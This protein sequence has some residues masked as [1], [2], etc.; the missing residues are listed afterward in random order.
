MR[1]TILGRR[2][3]IVTPPF[4]V[5]TTGAVVVAVVDG[6]GYMPI[7]VGTHAKP[8]FRQILIYVSVPINHPEVFVAI[9]RVEVFS[10]VNSGS[11]QLG[12]LRRRWEDGPEEILSID[13]GELFRVCTG[14]I[15]REEGCSPLNN[16]R[17]P[18]G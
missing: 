6:P 2:W 9:R 7:N 17:T 3:V 1:E 10:R 5:A 13:G 15:S 18:A 16:V 14:K 4:N 11:R 8:I 12:E